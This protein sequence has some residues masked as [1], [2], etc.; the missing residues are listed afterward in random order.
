MEGRDFRRGLAATGM[1][2]PTV[3]PP[4]SPDP[5]PG[6][7]AIVRA[8]LSTFRPTS[9]TRRPAFAGDLELVEGWQR[10]LY[11]PTSYSFARPSI[12]E[13][14]A[15]LGVQSRSVVTLS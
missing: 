11:L 9:P 13:Q 5:D 1:M 3:D 12:V 15:M 10:P 6:D 7:I 4:S 2:A 14:M 8:G